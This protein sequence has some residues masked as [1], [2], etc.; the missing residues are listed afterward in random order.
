MI[1]QRNYSPSALPKGTDVAELTSRIIG[2]LTL[3]IERSGI[4]Q[5]NALGLRV[6]LDWI[7][8]KTCF[9]DPVV[10]RRAVDQ[11]EQLLPL[12]EIAIDLRQAATPAFD[13]HLTNAVDALKG[14][15]PQNGQ[16]PFI[17]DA[18]KPWR[19]SIIWPF[20]R[21]FW[22]QLGDWEAYAKRGFEAALPSGGSDAN[23]PDAVQESVVEFWDAAPGPGQARQSASRHLRD[24]N[25]RRLG[26]ARAPVARSVPGVRYREGHR[27]L[28]SR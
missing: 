1:I 13:Q 17:L 4:D 12:C 2:P 28:P 8:Y 5:D 16:A 23:H 26:R 3:L 10:V 14:V 7:Q 25:R 20:N 21:L 6:H 19:E 27:L 15:A 11:R 24:G 18:F 22:Q 9:R